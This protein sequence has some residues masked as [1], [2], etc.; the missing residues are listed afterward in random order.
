[1]KKII[2][3][4]ILLLTLSCSNEE[5]E[6]QPL[7]TE[8]LSLFLDESIEVGTNRI[9]ISAEIK[10]YANFSVDEVGFCWSLYTNPTINND[11]IKSRL[12][13]GKFDRTITTLTEKTSYY[14]KA[15]ALSNNEYHYSSE[16]E[17]STRSIDILSEHTY[18]YN[19]NY[20][21]RAISATKTKDGGFVI[22]GYVNPLFGFTDADLLIL[23]YS[24][25]CDLVWNRV[26]SNTQTNQFANQIIEDTDGNLLVTSNLSYTS[27]L[28]YGT[29]ATLTKFD[30]MGNQIWEKTIDES[31]VYDG[32]SWSGISLIQTLDGN[33]AMAGNWIPNYNSSQYPDSNFSLVKY[34]N[35]GDLLFKKNY[36]KPESIEHAWALLENSNGD[37]MLVG[38]NPGQNNDSN[39]KYIKLTSD[40]THIWEKEYGGSK[41]DYSRSAIL[42]ND[43]NIVI[44]GYSNSFDDNSRAW[45]LK[46]NWDGDILWENSIGREDA[47]IYLNG[48]SAIIEDVNSN[49]LIAAESSPLIIGNDF[50]AYSDMYSIKVNKEGKLIWDKTFNSTETFKSFDSATSIVEL[51]NSEII[52]VG[53]KE[54]EENPRFDGTTSD[55]WII[56][57]KEN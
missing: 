57:T 25:N 11:T 5:G 46:I 23:K 49:L 20:E 19:S 12:I 52:L 16:I 10:D 1:M 39:L 51:S 27:G 31:G 8:Q 34:S 32:E 54:A 36:G 33:Y 38:T 42:T 7:I 14:L 47:K 21:E 26:L 48:S 6:V 28:I 35:S 40:G 2:I 43:G 30:S 24:A 13:D 50:Y 4:L 56:K 17:F 45:L 22:V 44:A 18:K 29:Y 37:L 53:D 55:I 3:P 15:Y 9:T 41:S